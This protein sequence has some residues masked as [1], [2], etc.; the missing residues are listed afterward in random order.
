MQLEP[1]TCYQALSARDSR[2]D[3][4]FFVG[5]TSTGIY[6]RPV[7]PA[8]T[9]GK[10]RCLFFRSAAEAEAAGLRACFRCRP[11]LAP[12]NASVDA[13]SQLV[14][15]AVRRIEAGALNEAS[16]EALAA[17]L[18]VTDR[19]LRRAMVEHLG[20][21]PI[22]L[23][24]TQRLALAKRL[25]QDTSLSLSDLAFASG[26]QSLRRFNAAFLQRFSRSPSAVRRDLGA[27]A[28]TFDAGA[29]RLRLDY[30]PPFAWKALLDFLKARA[31]PGIEHVGD[32]SYQRTIRLEGKR[33]WVSIAPAENRSALIATVS[34]SLLSV[35]MPVVVRLRRLF[36][37]D[38]Q[39]ARI[40]AQ[41]RRDATLAPLVHRKPG[42]R[43]PGAFDGFETATR[44]ILGQQ[45]TVK[46]ATT[47]AGR[48][49]EGFG[50]KIETPY[51]ALHSVFPSSEE[52]AAASLDDV[53]ALG[54]PR[55]R[56][57]AVLSLARAVASG[58]ELEPGA[59]SADTHAQLSQLPGF[60]AWTTEYVAMRALSWP[61]AFPAAD[62]WVLKALGVKTAKAAVARAESFRPWRSYAA[63]HL[64]SQGV[65]P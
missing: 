42:L 6:C 54:M 3:G 56:A 34:P 65:I 41:L 29:P 8:R 39:P 12:G 9:P 18:G 2:F 64:W 23:A 60:G 4:L 30:R 26:F 22:E 19:H 58:F 5:V 35:L 37:L 33:G 25:L 53:A 52:L 36:D 10:A 21:S 48:L 63:L 45:V 16:V 44:I 59:S 49:V 20:V 50:S 1:E 27:S 13:V 11:E 17:S 40:D 57:H 28:Q 7:C 32:D 55:A 47:L 46:G 62:L 61:D 15:R 14:A 51:A 38:A 31:I 43:V 24:Q